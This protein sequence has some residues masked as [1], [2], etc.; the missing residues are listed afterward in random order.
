V[1][2]RTD[3][4]RREVKRANLPSYAVVVYD[5]LLEKADWATGWLPDMRQPRS[6]NE[7]ALWAGMSKPLVVR[8]LKVLEDTGWVER[9][10]P[11]ILR[12]GL[13]TTYQLRTGH[14]LPARGRPMTEAERGRRYRQRRKELTDNQIVTEDKP[15]RHGKGVPS[16]T[17]IVIRST[18]NPR[19]TDAQVN[20]H[21]AQGALRGEVVGRE[22]FQ[23]HSMNAGQVTCPLCDRVH[24][25]C[26]FGVGLYCQRPGCRNPHHRATPSVFI[27]QGRASA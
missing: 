22:V 8:A 25:R 5:A 7:L 16:V 4:M 27:P 2:K 21:F 20:G 17:E 1:V 13:S 19:V 24:E 10:S 11:A 14:R 12:R 18:D 9:K 3:Q 6:L 15:G 23:D 26:I